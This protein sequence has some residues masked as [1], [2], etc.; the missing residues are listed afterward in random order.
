MPERPPFMA[1]MGRREAEEPSVSR[2]CACVL[3]TGKAGAPALE[4]SPTSVPGVFATV[5]GWTGTRDS[6]PFL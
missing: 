6:G 1:E 3:E 4:V 5:Q 2:S